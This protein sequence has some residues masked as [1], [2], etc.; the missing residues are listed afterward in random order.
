M[1]MNKLS[2]SIWGIFS[3][4]NKFFLDISKGRYKGYY[5]KGSLTNKLS[6]IGYYGFAQSAIFAGLQSGAFALM[7]NSDDE[8]LVAD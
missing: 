5:G 4:K 8:K 1:K 6:K 3:N 2:Y 7:T